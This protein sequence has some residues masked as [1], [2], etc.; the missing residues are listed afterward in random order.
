MLAIVVA[1]MLASG[2]Q[3]WEVASR[4]D[5]AKGEFQRT[6]LTSDGE[7]VLGRNTREVKCP[8]ASLWSSAI[9]SDGT[10]WFGTGA[11]TVC[12]LAS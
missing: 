3:A 8:G 2:T 11:G 7:V 12:R 6:C 5:L 4:L 1:V 10:T 9:A